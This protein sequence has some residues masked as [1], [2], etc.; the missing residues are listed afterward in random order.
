MLRPIDKNLVHPVDG[1][2]QLDICPGNGRRIV[3]EILAGNIPGRVT[4]GDEVKSVGSYVGQIY[5]VATVR[6]L[7]SKQLNLEKKV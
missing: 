7:Y 2:S 1:S 4:G 5:N 6:Q 3:G